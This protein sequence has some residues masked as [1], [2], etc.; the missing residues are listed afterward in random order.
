MERDRVL[1]CPKCGGEPYIVYRRQNQQPDG[2]LLPSYESVLWPA[3][4]DV[5]PPGDPA[6]IRCPTCGEPLRST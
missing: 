5:P 6:T 1:K 3:H 2:T 4:P